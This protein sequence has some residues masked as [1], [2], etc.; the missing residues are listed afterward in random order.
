MPGRP[1]DKTFIFFEY[2]GGVLGKLKFLNGQYFAQVE[3][4][5]MSIP[6]N[7]F[8]G[9]ERRNYPFFYVGGGISYPSSNNW[10]S[11]LTILYNLHPDSNQEFFPLTFSY[12]FIYNF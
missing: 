6:S 4:D 2:G 1:E 8:A 11:E 7:Y 5:L 10:S 12:A 3:Y 9:D